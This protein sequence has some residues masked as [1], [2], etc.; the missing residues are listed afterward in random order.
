[1]LDCMLM[2]RILDHLHHFFVPHTDNAYR[3]RFLHSSWVAFFLI[4]IILTET[5]LVSNLLM[6]Q[7][8]EGFLA[9]VI[10]GD[11]ISLTNKQRQTAQARELREN[12]VLARAA[13][14]KAEDMA[15]QGYF[16]HTG[17][18]GKR[19]WAWFREAGYA[20]KYAGENLAVKFVDSGQVVTAW[21]NSPTHR[22]NMVNT[23][24]T[25]I[26]VGVAEGIYQGKSATF[27]VQF[28]AAPSAVALWARP[29][30]MGASA[31]SA[32][33]NFFTATAFSA[34]S[35]VESRPL[36]LSTLI[37]LCIAILLLVAVSISFLVHI[38]IQHTRSLVL[39]LAVA[40]SAILIMF[41]NHRLLGG[42][43]EVT[44]QA[45]AIIESRGIGQ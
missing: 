19:P 37:L 23:R 1:M 40:A 14:A 42:V 24:F 28:F 27:V 44:A 15:A 26:G 18:D 7:S 41:A 30:S 5:F 33:T 13:Q 17:P 2:R 6:R 45:A 32:D 4:A 3:P 38:Q 39:A 35:W 12:A 8:S 9:A 43:T 29:S 10:S 11:V 31:I 25:E 16:S 20:Y 22:A 36:Y 34:L 21:M